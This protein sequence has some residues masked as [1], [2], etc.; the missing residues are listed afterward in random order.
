MNIGK[1]IKKAAKELE[2][3]EIV[4]IPTETVYGLAA[5]A[6][7]SKAILKV[8]KAKNRPK[9]DP[10]IVHVKNI[11]EL[12][13]IAFCSPKEIEIINT[14]S[15]GA[16]TYLLEKKDNIDDLITAG[17]N[18]V[19]VRIPRHKLTQELLS[20]INF[21]LVA[22]SANPFGYVSPSKAQHVLESLGDKVSYII[23]GEDCEHGLESTIISFNTQEKVI[24]IHRLGA[25]TIEELEEKTGYDIRLSINNNSNPQAPGMLDKHYSPRC[26]LLE[27][28]SNIDTSNSVV[29]W[30]GKDHPKN[31][32]LYNLSEGQNFEEAA[33]NLFTLL[34]NLDKDGETE[35]FVKLLPNIGLGRAIND[36]L[37]RAMA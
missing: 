15:P 21:P 13:K 6:F 18:K 32:R 34:R 11:D 24:N 4:A 36:R 10:L 5:S 26:K 30:F 8:F 12:K 37:K 27:Y 28:K 9:F 3:S 19:A 22:P 23:D 14:F 16:L 25:I 7:D 2:N 20:I 31:K 17:S 35:A 1:D 33:K 29:I